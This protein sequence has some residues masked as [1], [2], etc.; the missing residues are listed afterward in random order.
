M[1]CCIV[2]GKDVF[3]A[4]RAVETNPPSAR[5]MRHQFHSGCV[6]T[7]FGSTEFQLRHARQVTRCPRANA[8]PTHARYLVHRV[9]FIPSLVCT[10]QF[11]YSREVAASA[12]H[13]C[14]A[15][16][17][18]SYPLSCKRVRWSVQIAV[19]SVGGMFE[20]LAAIVCDSSFS[21]AR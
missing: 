12:G 17:Q 11:L 7:G 9:R 1:A 19:A 18:A 13:R 15:T 16:G 4:P 20:C 2:S 21:T 6:K 3:H 5:I 8:V 14:G 10:A